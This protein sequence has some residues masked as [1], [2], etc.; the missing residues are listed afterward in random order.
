[1]AT[2]TK[3]VLIADDDWDLADAFATR[4]KGLGLKVQTAHDALATMHAL[5]NETPDLLILDVR[6][7]DGNGLIVCETMALDPDL[8]RIPVIVITGLHDPITVRRCRSSGAQYVFKAPDA[9]QRIEPLIWQLLNVSSTGSSDR[10]A[11]G[12][13]DAVTDSAPGAW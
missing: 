13:A 10:L 2:T 11:T 8:S 12:R 9:W 7:P 4:I 3:T 6:M 5:Q 1:V